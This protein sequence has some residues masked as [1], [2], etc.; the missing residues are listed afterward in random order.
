MSATQ[1]SWWWDLYTG[2]CS[3]LSSNGTSSESIKQLDSGFGCEILVVVVVDLNH[4]RIHAS[5]ETF[6]FEN[7]EDAIWG[8]CAVRRY[9]EMFRYGLDN[10]VTS[11]ATELAWCLRAHQC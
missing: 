1:G 9:A 6:D 8:C 7:G 4:W 11:T 10:L 3:I 5:S 2:L